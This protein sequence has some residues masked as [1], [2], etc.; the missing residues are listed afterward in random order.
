MSLSVGFM[1]LEVRGLP[2]TAFLAA[3]VV[4]S[5]VIFRRFVLRYILWLWIPL[6][7]ILWVL[8]LG[9]ILPSATLHYP[10]SGKETLRHIWN[11]QHRIYKGDLVPGQSSFD[12]GFLFPTD[13]F[14]MRVDWWG[15]RISGCAT[16]TP[17]WKGTDIYLDEDGD[18]DR[19]EGNQTD[20]QHLAPCP[21]GD[22]VSP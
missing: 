5:L 6:G 2:R 21:E 10:K 1:W 19:S 16:I 20:W 15:G 8:A 9:L 4:I 11:V 12:Q 14:F 3:G 13:R 22:S 18:F 17:T 7:P